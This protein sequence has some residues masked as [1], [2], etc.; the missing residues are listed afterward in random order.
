M[1]AGQVEHNSSHKMSAHSLLSASLTP[2][3]AYLKMPTITMTDIKALV[4]EITMLSNGLPSSIQ[5][6]TKEDKIWRVKNADGGDTAHE[7]F[8][9]R[10]NAIFGEDCCDSSGCLLH[11]R[12]GKHGLGLICSYL[13]QIDWVVD[14]FPLDIVEIKLQ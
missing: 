2:I 14:D 12:K 13:S 3:P 5:T 10:F 8:N 9:K 6:G 7:T 1:T 4:K 11:I